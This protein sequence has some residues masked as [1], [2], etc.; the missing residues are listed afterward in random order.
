MRKIFTLI[1]LIIF[2]LALG[3]A[4]YWVRDGFAIIRLDRWNQ[5]VP[6][7]WWEAEADKAIQQ[8]FYYFSRGRQCFAFISEDEKYVLKL[9][10]TDHFHLPLWLRAVSLKS[11]SEYRAHFLADIKHR[12]SFLLESFLICFDELK[13]LTAVIGMNLSHQG[14]VGKSITIIDQIGRSYEL[15][16]KNTY[17]ILQHKRKL[18]RDVFKEAV[19]KE[20]T[21]G[22]EKIVDSLLELLV[23]RAKKGIFNKDGSFMRNF[24]YD[25]QKAYQIDV[26]SF[27]RKKNLTP[28]EAY[29]KS[30][31]SNIEPLREWIEKEN[32]EW[33]KMLDRKLDMIYKNGF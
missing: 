8:K 14:T 11:L 28:E 6:G 32:P 4:W 19:L 27:Y 16:L 1:G 33:L 9:P 30:I 23:E 2:C 13:D 20:G 7:T 18:F 17:F 10:R 29:S 22:V 24:G 5:T 3:K 12:E 26:G 15:P 31:A 21:I 25:G